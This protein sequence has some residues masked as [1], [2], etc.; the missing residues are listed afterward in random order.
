MRF[1]IILPR[2]SAP[3]QH[4][5]LPAGIAYIASVL[6]KAGHEVIG[7]N[8]NQSTD[9]AGK[10]IAEAVRL[11]RPDAIATGALS[12]HYR[13]IKYVLEG[14]RA[15]VPGVPI[16]M[17]GGL[18]SSEPELIMN[19]LG[20]D[21]GVIGEGER[22][23][24]ELAERLGAG[25]EPVDVDGLIFRRSNGTLH[26]TPPRAAIKDLESLPYPNYELFD[27][28]GYFQYRLPNDNR[29]T[30]VVEQPREICVVASRSCPY[31]CTF[32]YHP[33][34]NTYRERSLDDVLAE[35]QYWK[36]KHQINLLTILDELFSIKKERLME[37]CRRIA[38]LD[39]KWCAQMRVTDVDEAALAAMKESGCWGISYGFESGCDE[40]LTSMKK[41]T[42]S[43]DIDR[44]VEMTFAAG[45]QVQGNFIFGD[46]AETVE[47]VTE[48]LSMWLR[49]RKN[50]I[51][52]FPIEVYP[53]TKLYKDAVS[54]GLIRNP[55]GFIAAG[56]PPV[57]IT[58]MSPE[59][60]LRTH[61]AMLILSNAYNATPAKVLAVREMAPHPKRGRILSLTICCPHCQTEIVYDNISPQGATKF[62]C[63]V[64][65][66]RFDIPPFDQADDYPPA[67]RLSAAFKPSPEQKQ[68][69]R[70]FLAEGEG[71]RSVS[72]HALQVDLLGERYLVPSEITPQDVRYGT[73]NIYWLSP[74]GGIEPF[75]CY[76]PDEF[77]ALF[78]ER[79]A[80][81]RWTQLLGG[82]G[83]LPDGAFVLAGPLDDTKALWSWVP[84]QY[85]HR[86]IHFWDPARERAA[87]ETS[88]VDSGWI[89]RH[90][91][92]PILVAAAIKQRQISDRV[93]AMG[94]EA[95]AF[96]DAHALAVLRKVTTLP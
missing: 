49:T 6:E 63:R 85:K 38:P 30:T 71:I 58:A 66:R 81:P 1:L 61:L 35:I 5:L 52:M 26:R 70:R 10:V 77:R 37:F 46:V 59:E 88:E 96:F 79:Y 53:G 54:S 64:C 33:I 86:Q 16:I 69:V 90:P 21:Y 7:L 22:T 28:E 51:W 11:N 48:T 2:V 78:C 74:E 13:S 80:A 56:C 55:E 15:A 93:E 94:R 44:A 75:I 73:A 40:V 87:E 25:V 18:L 29:G 36:E 76:N 14:C 41:H 32:C 62:S 12:A 23:I 84:G 3:H 60:N 39:L 67:F 57:N 89:L 8:L 82:T 9:L 72:P 83:T 47:S 91:E 31:Q 95:Q 27:L 43:R 42:K 34:G 4:Y 24:V 68:S 17:G 45:I 20:P 50:Q 92:V 65:N 19:A